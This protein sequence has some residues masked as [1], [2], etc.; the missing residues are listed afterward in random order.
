MMWNI[1][2][3][4]VLTFAYLPKVHNFHYRYNNGLF[5]IETILLFLVLFFTFLE[6]S[7]GIVE[8]EHLGLK[9]SH[10]FK[11]THMLYLQYIV[12]NLFT[13]QHL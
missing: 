7:R 5:L 2:Y 9:L 13:K 3:Y 11:N 12:Y 1:E 8:V 4:C 10:H 6:A